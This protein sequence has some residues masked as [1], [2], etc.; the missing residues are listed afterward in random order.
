MTMAGD[1]CGRQAFCS[2]RDSPSTGDGPDHGVID[3][4]Y[5]DMHTIREV[6]LVM[7]CIY[8]LGVE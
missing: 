3:G 8:R 7:S 4:S 1:R 6:A 5:M 2:E